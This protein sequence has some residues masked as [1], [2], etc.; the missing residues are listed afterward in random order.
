MY[1]H[2]VAKIEVEDIL[3]HPLRIDVAK[4]WQEWPLERPLPVDI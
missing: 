2:G 3:L 1:G 4:M